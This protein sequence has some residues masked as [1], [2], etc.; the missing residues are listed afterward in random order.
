MT[1]AFYL[2]E[3]IYDKNG[4]PYDYRFLEINPAYERMMG[5]TSEQMLGRSLFEV[6]PNANPITIE[7]YNEIALSRK[8]AHFEIFSQVVTSKYLDVYAFSPEKG[9]LAVIFRDITKRKRMEEALEESEKQYRMLFDKSMDAIILTDPRGVGI[10]LSANPAACRILGWS[11]EELI[12]K[13]LDEI[14]DV[15]NPALSTL[16]DENIPSG[17]AKSQINYRHKDGT[18]LT[19]E[20]SSTFFVD[21]NGEPRAVTILRDITERKRA[22][23]AL[24]ESEKK[25]RNIVETANEGIWVVG[26]D[27]KTTYV[28]EKLAEILGYSREEMIG[29][30]GRDF[31]DNENKAI[32]KQTLE[33]RQKGIS[34]IYELKLIRKDGLPIWMLVNTKSLLDEHGKFAGSLG[35][36]IDITE[37]KQAEEAMR[38]SEERYRM[39]FTNTT[40]AFLLGEVICDK[41]GEPCD[42]ICLDANPAYE[43]NSGVK[44]EIILGR[45]VRELFPDANL[46]SIKRYGEVAL[47]GHPTHFEFF[48][49]ALNRYLDVNVFS[50]EKGKFAVI[51]RDATER[52]RAE[53]TL[54]YHANLVENVSDAIISTDKELKIRSWNKAAE[55]IYGWQ[56]GE[57][58]DLKG[59]DV[60]QTTFPEGLKR[61]GVT[62]DIF[63]KGYWEGELIQ[64]TKDDRNINVYAKSMQLKDE[65]GV[66]IGGVSI[67]SDITERKRAEE[68]LHEAYETLQVQS[69]ELQVS[70]EELKAQ[71]EELHKTNEALRE[72]EERER[73]RLEELTVVLDSVPA[74][75]WVA[76]DPQAI[77]IT[78]NKL[79]YE[80][81]LIPEGSNASK[82]APEVERPET[83]RMFK[84]GVEIPPE[85]MPVQM[86]ARGTEI[87]DYEFD[88]VY[89]N[90]GVRN[91]LGNA[92][93]LYDKQGNPRG[94]VSAF[95]DIT[96]RKRAEGALRESEEKYRN[97]VETANEGIWVLNSDIKITYANNKM[98]EML[99]YSPEEMIGRSGTDF[100]DAEY[101]TY[102]EL[103]MEKRRQGIDEVHENKLVRKD[104]STLWVLVNSKSL[105]DKDGK[106][107]GIL[108]MLT[109]I[110][111]LKNAQEERERLLDQVQQEKDRLSALVNSITDEVWFADTQKKISLVNPAV[112]N[113]FGSSTFD[114]IDVEAIAW[115]LEVYRPDGT[116]RPVEE[117]P[118][119]RALC[120]EIVKNQEEIIRTAYLRRVALSTGERR[121][122]TQ[123]KRQYHWFSVC[124]SGHHRAKRSRKSPSR[125]TRQFRRKS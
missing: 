33:E 103:R 123:Y 74:A 68:A 47:S 66:V 116:P 120:G 46:M 63:E 117:A 43:V 38:K 8:S 73:A 25:Y 84:D 72:S 48:S 108:A 98:A 5:I 83:F 6:F 51:F 77:H 78:G 42:Y 52:K 92:R 23:E 81:L 22:E 101:K 67:S 60:L 10:I 62:K 28:N 44:K 87:Q 1:E 105:F 37:R 30:Y 58:I 39:L 49:Q 20:V 121:S 119:L 24:R 115:S 122:G 100:V 40:E 95:I 29:K 125:S 102:T 59:S 27:L 54:R 110:T 94:S 7:K 111:E 106:F 15:K 53:E 55:R 26:A 65:V 89:P 56:A 104:G 13:G 14:F 17:S 118:L 18:I 80:W 12:L 21:R 19:G 4:K 57:V 9:K 88:F 70:N 76:H 107:T 32:L 86:S 82:S 3:V 31:A 69:E 35:M 71:S 41:D 64:K 85:D 99:G 11:E 113:E 2:V 114:N 75:V 90:G 45:S 91:V 93:P 50:P 124:S 36:L 79:S 96:G 112:L 109:D 97:I 34:E 16:L 61:E